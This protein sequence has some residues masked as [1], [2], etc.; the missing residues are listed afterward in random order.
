MAVHRLRQTRVRGRLVLRTLRL[1]DFEK[2][3]RRLAVDYQDIVAGQKHNAVGTK[4]LAGFLVR[5]GELQDIIAPLLEPERLERIPEYDFR[6]CPRARGIFQYALER[7]DD[8]AFFLELRA[9]A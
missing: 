3:L 7:I 1:R 9:E 6:H 8:R 2:I 4:T 5:S